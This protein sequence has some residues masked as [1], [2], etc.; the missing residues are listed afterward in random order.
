MANTK[1]IKN[2]NHTSQIDKGSP[3]IT[4]YEIYVTSL[5]YNVNCLLVGTFVTFQ[6]EYHS[7]YNITRKMYTSNIIT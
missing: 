3:G 6:H 7:K 5:K 1:D 2:Y 4:V